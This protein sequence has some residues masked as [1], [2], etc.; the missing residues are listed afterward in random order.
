MPIVREMKTL[1]ASLFGPSPVTVQKASKEPL[2]KTTFSEGV[3]KIEGDESL[4]PGLAGNSCDRVTLSGRTAREVSALKSGIDARADLPSPLLP[5]VDRD[6]TAA[7]CW[8][9]P[10]IDAD[11]PVVALLPATSV[12]HRAPNPALDSS[13]P[14]ESPKTRRL[15]RSV[16]GSSLT[17]SLPPENEPGSHIHIRA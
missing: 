1:F 13:S 3:P 12:N 8:A 7:A 14:Q 15:V 9:P 2:R 4:S 16:Y 6:Q 10:A 17:A 11:R 5:A